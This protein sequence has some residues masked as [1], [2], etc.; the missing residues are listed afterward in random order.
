[1]CIVGCWLPIVKLDWCICLK[2][3]GCFI[4]RVAH[5]ISWVHGWS[6]FVFT[7]L[8]D[9]NRCISVSSTEAFPVRRGGIYTWVEHYVYEGK[10]LFF[11]IKWG[12]QGLKSQA[13]TLMRSGG[14]R[15][16]Y[17][18]AKSFTG[19]FI[20]DVKWMSFNSNSIQ[21][22]KAHGMKI[23]LSKNS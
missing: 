6:W 11:H 13:C 20:S 5:L 4:Y 9:S 23:I 17:K 19:F 12:P 14:L 21:S 10:S 7:W 18:L 2:N 15:A 16:L 1:M 22:N 8:D 3:L